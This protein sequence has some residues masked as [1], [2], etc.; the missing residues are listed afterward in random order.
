MTLGTKHWPT[1][2]FDQGRGFER[3]SRCFEFDPSRLAPGETA[4]RC[5][6]SIA[7]ASEL[8]FPR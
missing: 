5:N 6:K 3:P 8:R 4:T 1:I 2:D 7:A